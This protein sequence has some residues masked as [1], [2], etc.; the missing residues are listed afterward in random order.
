M[1]KMGFVWVSALI[2]GQC[3][4]GAR[5]GGANLVQAPFSKQTQECLNCHKLIHSGLVADWLNSRHTQTTPEEALKKKDLERRVSSTDIPDSLKKVAVGCYEC[6]SLNIDKH[7]DNFEHFGT[8]INV[9]V[10]PADCQTCHAEE[11]R[12]YA[13]SKKAFALV[14]LGKNPVYHMFV[15]SQTGG[16]DI[17]EG[18][19]VFT[20]SSDNAK[21]EACY[22]CHG[23]EIQVKGLRKISTDAGEIE[24]PQLTGWPN[25]GVGRMNPD[26]S[27]GACTACHP[28]HSF[29]IEIAR[30]PYTCSQCHLEPDVPA[31]EVYRES[32]HG[33]ICQSKQADWNWEAVPWKPGK[34][35]QAPTCAACHSSLMATEDGDVIAPRTHDF[36]ARLW[37]RL[38][39]LPYAHPQPKHGNT[40]TLKNKDG[41]P[42]PTSFSGEPASEGLIT[43]EEQTRRRKAMTS[44]CQS[45]HSQTWATDFFAKLDQTVAEADKMVL[46]ATQLMQQAWNQGLANKTNPFDEPIEHQWMKQ[47]VYFA[48]SLRYA[49]AMSGPDYA[50]FKNG[51]VELTRNL[52]EMEAW[53]E[54]KGKK[55][56]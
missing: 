52:K 18:K 37:V 22:S 41:L 12:Q 28:R 13:E 15:E 29:S 46:A 26:G 44:L 14:N 55:K 4:G 48:N 32:K 8:K 9:L 39:G 17:K 51:W 54:I 3:G 49:S 50:A 35:F 36:G 27:Q 25:Q 21:H 53:I 16:Y 47:W 24:V 20:R 19:A 23:T 11:A 2:A 30:K 31:W 1:M 10:T 7:K 33:N 56:E 38:F 42:L 45:C 43:A 40:T 6:H 34:D 5:E